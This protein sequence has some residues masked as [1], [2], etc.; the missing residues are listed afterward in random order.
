MQSGVSCCAKEVNDGLA[1]CVIFDAQLCD[2]SFCCSMEQDTGVRLKAL[3]ECVAIPGV[4]NDGIFIRPFPVEGLGFSYQSG[5]ER[6]E[7]LARFN[8]IQGLES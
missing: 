1:C 8:F 7:V 2:E 3:E 5:L 4:D 6:S